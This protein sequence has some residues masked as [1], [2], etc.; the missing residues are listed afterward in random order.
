MNGIDEEIG[1]RI[2]VLRQ[3]RQMTVEAAAV[4]M[5][6]SRQDVDGYEAG[7]KRISA[8]HLFDFSQLFGVPIGAFF[9]TLESSPARSGWAN[10]NLD[11]RGFE[12]SQRFS[13]LSEPQKRAILSLVQSLSF[14]QLAWDEPKAPRRRDGS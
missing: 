11:S 5:G 10:A 13:E 6:I 4:R 1:R 14:M 12:L 3:I 8:P 7:S 2:R 9:E